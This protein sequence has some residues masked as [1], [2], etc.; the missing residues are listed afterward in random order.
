LFLHLCVYCRPERDIN[1]HQ[2]EMPPAVRGWFSSTAS[3]CWPL[4]SSHA[5]K[6]KKARLKNT[7]VNEF[8]FVCNTS[9]TVSESETC[10]QCWLVWGQRTQSA[11]VL[12]GHHDGKAHYQHSNHSRQQACETSSL[13]RTPINLRMQRMNAE[14]KRRNVVH[15]RDLSF[16]ERA[17]ELLYHRGVGK[18]RTSQMFCHGCRKVPPEKKL[19]PL[20]QPFIPSWLVAR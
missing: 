6:I 17:R 12:L 4:W 19:I 7:T 5:N 11:P 3:R 13:L 18:N 10:G 9:L 20:P 2:R 8:T 15:V 16:L 1:Q 14:R